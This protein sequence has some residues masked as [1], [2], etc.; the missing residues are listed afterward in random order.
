V[1]QVPRR[2]LTYIRAV[3]EQLGPGLYESLVTEGLRAELDRLAAPLGAERRSL[4]SAEAADRVALHLAR[5]IDRALS[6]V[7]EEERVGVGLTVAR[8]L[9]TRLGEVTAPDRS[10]LP[11]DPAQVLHAIVVRRPDGSKGALAEPLIPLL[12]TTLLTNAPG[13]PNLWSQLRSEIESADAV[14]VVMAFIRRSG[15]TP[16]LGELRRH[17]DAGRA[18][19]VLTT[20]YTGS[21]ERAALDALVDLGASV[22]ISYDLS[23][24][25]LHAKAWLFHRASGFSTAYVGSSNLTHSAQATGLEWN[26]RASAGRN[27]ALVAKFAAVFDGYWEGGDFVAYEPSQFEEERARAGR[28]DTGPQVILSPIELR[29]WPFQE[30]L[31][32]LIDRPPRGDPGPESRDVSSRAPEPVVRREVGRRGPAHAVRA[33]LRVDSEP[34][35]ERSHGAA[36]GALRRRHRRRVP[37]RRR[38]LVRAGARPSSSAGAARPHRDARAQ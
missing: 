6:D 12:D 31:L 24:T 26:I 25:R 38:A 35:R 23:T 2:R 28:R 8:A 29:P 27:P 9:L 5:Q 13:E 21:T 7:G 22:R 30:R 20:T 18:I 14:D 4:R 17:A 16:L 11:I 34:E 10:V 32:E 1:A 36:S 3:T 15:V 33:R 37:P 19:R